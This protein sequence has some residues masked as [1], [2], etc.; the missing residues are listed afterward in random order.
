M[1][2]ILF[3]LTVLLVVQAYSNW[4]SALSGA[5]RRL[6]P[7]DG[8]SSVSHVRKTKTPFFA[9]SGVPH[10][11]RVWQYEGSTSVEDHNVAFLDHSLHCKQTLADL[12]SKMSFG[13]R[14]HPPP[15]R[16]VRTVAVNNT[17]LS[18]FSPPG[19]TYRCPFT[20]AFDGFK[21]IFG[22]SSGFTTDSLHWSQL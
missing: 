7:V 22:Q 9:C 17:R 21:S 10:G 5:R 3:L 18:I 1:D 4:C 19:P 20:G 14:C 11:T 16:S 2:P 8:L 12:G 13:L 6:K 15:C